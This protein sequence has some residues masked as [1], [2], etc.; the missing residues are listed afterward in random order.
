VNIRVIRGLKVA[1]REIR[2]VQRKSPS[3]RIGGA[4]RRAL[5]STKSVAQFNRPAEA[6]VVVPVV[7]RAAEHL[8]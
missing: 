3:E 4:W 5:L 2:G 7:V 1:I 6:G 8:P